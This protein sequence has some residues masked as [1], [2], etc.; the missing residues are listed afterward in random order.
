MGTFDILSI[1]PVTPCLMT[2]FHRPR[3]MG[4]AWVMT[5]LD[6][7]QWSQPPVFAR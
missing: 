3:N 7:L 1:A 6:N 5:L 4:M 2:R